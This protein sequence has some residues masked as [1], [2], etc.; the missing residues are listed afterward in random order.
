MRPANRS[1]GNKQKILK[2]N[3]QGIRTRVSES[4]TSLSE[5][6]KNEQVGEI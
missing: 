2:K 1:K 4:R 3:F 5:T 6:C